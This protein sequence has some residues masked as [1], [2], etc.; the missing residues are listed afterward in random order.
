MPVAHLPGPAGDALDVV[1]P[2]VLDLDHD[3]PDAPVQDQHVRLVAPGGLFGKH[4]VVGEGHALLVPQSLFQPVPDLMLA[5]RA[6]RRNR[7][8]ELHGHPPPR[9]ITATNHA[10]PEF[11]PMYVASW[12]QARLFEHPSKP[13]LA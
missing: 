4:R 1:R 13:L 9:P 5:R 2:A 7:R 11:L 3:E 10:L 6:A 12:K 8:Q